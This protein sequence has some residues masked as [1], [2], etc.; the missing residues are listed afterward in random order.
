MALRDDQTMVPVHKDINKKL[1][2]YSKH[3]MRR[4]GKYGEQSREDFI[5]VMVGMYE[6]Q[7][8]EV[9]ENQE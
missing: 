6:D 7:F 3:D 2:R 1:L 9:L 4:R 5:S 8:P